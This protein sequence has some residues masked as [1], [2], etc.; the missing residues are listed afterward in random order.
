[1]SAAP[2][3]GAFLR[4]D[5]VLCRHSHFAAARHPAKHECHRRR[6]VK[7]AISAECLSSRT[8]RELFAEVESSGLGWSHFSG[9]TPLGVQAHPIPAHRRLHPAT[10]V[11]PG[12]LGVAHSPPPAGL[13][14]RFPAKCRTQ[15]R[16][17]TIASAKVRRS[18][19]N[20]LSAQHLRHGLCT[21]HGGCI[22]WPR[23]HPTRTPPPRMTAVTGRGPPDG[24]PAT[25]PPPGVSGVW[26]VW[27]PRRTPGLRKVG[28]KKRLNDAGRHR[29]PGQLEG[30]YCERSSL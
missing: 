2:A 24:G 14:C 25:T 29:R 27:G 26:G 9:D 16:S 28:V 22:V 15:G 6:F 5:G 12:R 8:C 1:M 23:P 3:G 17:M 19:P 20:L 30:E 7:S 18:R 13:S 21:R 11:S 10:P 4:S